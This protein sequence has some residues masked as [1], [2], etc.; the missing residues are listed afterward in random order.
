MW[1]KV[2]VMPDA[3]KLVAD[4]RDAFAKEG[5]SLAESKHYDDLERMK[6]AAGL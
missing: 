2:K 6:A 4:A 3:E 5:L 1:A